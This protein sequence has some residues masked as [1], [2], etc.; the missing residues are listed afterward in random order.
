ML[1]HCLGEGE[2]FQDVFYYRVIVYPLLHLH[3]DA[4]GVEDDVSGVAVGDAVR[5]EGVEEFLIGI[6]R[7]RLRAE[8]ERADQ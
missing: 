7:V 8:E 2:V 6:I 3:T 1:R 5:P 4:V